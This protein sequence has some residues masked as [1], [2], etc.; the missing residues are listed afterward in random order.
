MSNR[1]IGR[2]SPR[3]ISAVGAVVPTKPV[4]ILRSRALAI[5]FALVAA[6]AYA[7]HGVDAGDIDRNAA[8]CTDFFDFANGAWRASH[9]IGRASCRERV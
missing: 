6:P 8:A 1:S 7:L 2:T 5:A 4:R 9:Q 3:K